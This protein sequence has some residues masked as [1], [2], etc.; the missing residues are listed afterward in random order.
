MYKRILVYR[1]W[2]FLSSVM[3]V[4]FILA[5]MITLSAGIRHLVL[6]LFVLGDQAGRFLWCC[7]K[8]DE[9][10]EQVRRIYGILWF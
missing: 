2:M 3:V 9:L 1:T 6:L 7:L 10:A 8:A 5:Y 4:G